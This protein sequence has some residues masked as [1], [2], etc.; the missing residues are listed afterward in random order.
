ME[1]KIRRQAR[2]DGD[3][4]FD[5]RVV[6]EHVNQFTDMLVEEFGDAPGQ[7]MDAIAR[8]VPAA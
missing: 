1:T 5:E 7:V 6:Q 8:Q 2:K 3:V 4:V